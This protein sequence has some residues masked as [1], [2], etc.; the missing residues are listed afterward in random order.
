MNNSIN[1]NSIIIRPGELF[2]KGKNKRFFENVLFDNIKHALNKYELCVFRSQNRIYVEKFDLTLAD[3]I[4]SDLKCVFGI[5]SISKAYKVSSELEQ[6]EK[7]STQIVPNI[8]RFRVTVNRAD[9]SFPMKSMELAAHIGSILLKAHNLLKVD[10]FNYEFNLNID[11]RENK[12][13]YVFFDTIL[14]A[15][16]LPVGT[17][18]KGLLLLSG[19]IDSPV[20]GY[21]MAKRGM[22][23][24]AVHFF[25]H[26]Y[27]SELALQKVRDLAK[28]LIKYTKRI[29]LYIVS[30]TEIQQNIYENC[31]DSYLITIMRRFMMRV[32]ER[33][34]SIEGA[35]ILITGES[36]GQ[37]ASQTVPS[38]IST[39]DAT[40]MS[41]LRPLIA[42]DK[43]ETI[44]L[45]KNISTYDISIRPYEDCCTVFVPEK[46]V[47][48]PKIDLVRKYEEALDI[49][50]LVSNALSSTK[51]EEI[52]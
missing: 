9:K 2:L 42:F 40:N 22:E 4:I 13:T 7:L 39:D 29:S 50:N 28:S 10:L 37:V 41:V 33:I 32:A 51:L 6:I 12:Y 44:N 15:G 45:S 43:F 36:L 25:S 24:S 38:L 46:P 8:G 16:G 27:T 34:A 48:K 18:G 11:I 47:I 19:G 35:K 23:L 17:S 14:G 20:A 31:P 49:D 5:Y 52:V 26:P 30:F 3:T 21:L 1:I